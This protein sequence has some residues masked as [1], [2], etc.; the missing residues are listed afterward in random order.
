MF[1]DIVEVKSPHAGEAISEAIAS[2]C[3]SYC[4]SVKSVTLDEVVADLLLPVLSVTS[5]NASNMIN[6]LNR[7]EVFHR[8]CVAHVL[9][10]IYKA[11]IA[12][13]C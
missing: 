2:A 7:F 3:D 13:H 12:L 6:A 8:R 9:N 10:L 1:A 11:S 4:L 5:D